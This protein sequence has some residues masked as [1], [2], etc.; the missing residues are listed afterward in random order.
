MEEMLYH[1]DGDD[2]VLGEISRSEAHSKEILHRTGIV[3]LMNSEDK[4][5]INM[6][7]SGHETFPFCFDSSASFHVT[8]GETYEDSGI[9]EMKEETGIRES[10]KYIG[11]FMH[12]DPPENQMVAVFLCKSDDEPEIDA[13]E[14]S[15][16]KFHSLNEVENLIRREEIGCI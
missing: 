12:R 10:L 5:L 11:K 14:F 3:F 2:E 15:S 8:Y 9:R 7:N 1:V 16:H 4:V 6:R 13:E